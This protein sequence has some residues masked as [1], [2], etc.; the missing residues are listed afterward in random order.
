[1]DMHNEEPSQ[2]IDQKI[3]DTFLH[4]LKS[5]LTDPYF[6]S[7]LEAIQHPGWQDALA[8]LL[9]KFKTQNLCRDNEILTDQALEEVKKWLEYA[10]KHLNK[11]NPYTMDQMEWHGYENELESITQD[12]TW[13]RLQTFEPDKAHF[14]QNKQQKYSEEL[15]QDIE[16][17]RRE[18]LE[19]RLNS[20]PDLVAYNWKQQIKNQIEELSHKQLQWETE[21]LPQLAE[22]FSLEMN[23]K[24]EKLQQLKQQFSSLYS[25]IGG[26][27]WDYM[28]GSGE[29][30]DGFGESEADGN[31][32]GGLQYGGGAGF[33]QQVN[34]DTLEEYAKLLENNK[35]LQELAE[36]MGRFRQAEKEFEEEYYTKKV[37]RQEWRPDPI[38]RSEIVGVKMGD[39]LHNMLISQA[40]LL[41]HPKTKKIFI[42]NLAEK[43]LLEW[44]FAGQYP[45][46]FTEEQEEVR[47]VAKEEE[48]RGPI[49]VCVDTSGSMAGTPE[50]VAK[51]I[52]FALLSI[53]LREKRKCYVITFS[54][55]IMTQNICSIEKLSEFLKYS[56]GGGTSVEMAL[57]EA[58]N[59]CKSETYKNAD[60][61][62]VSDFGLDDVSHSL[63]QD[64]D[65]LKQENK[66]KLHSLNIGRGSQPLT[67]FDN[68]WIYDSHT[69]HIRNASRPQESTF[70]K[71]VF[72]NVSQHF[73][74]RN[75]S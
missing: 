42:K 16:P 73:G 25:F 29:G 10:Q 66:T 50:Q 52:T 2:T 45:Y 51:T 46:D 18:F 7:D 19:N 23:Q 21:T 62:V 63:K 20:I 5:F 47:Q 44:Q 60:V 35:E 68:D 12:K 75:D 58:I 24:F 22:A 3:Q 74:Q 4:E 65:K 57:R 6:Q 30:M 48:G 11:H 38:G 54:I 1:M 64:I 72:T 36:I 34:F 43:K 31:I 71:N 39:N 13:E 70:A 49:I 32:P 40:A 8:T 55:D 67:F 59:Q 27:A 9:E 69:H 15:K 28:F 37:E 53:A 56:S 41:K 14:Y 61:L 33:W 17:H 26:S